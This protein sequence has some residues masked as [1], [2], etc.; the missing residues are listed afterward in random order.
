MPRYRV[1]FSRPNQA[2]VDMIIEAD[3]EEEARRLAYEQSWHD[4]TATPDATLPVSIA[5]YEQPSAPEPLIGP[6]AL[7]AGATAPRTWDTA[8]GQTEEARAGSAAPDADAQTE[9]DADDKVVSFE[10]FRKRRMAR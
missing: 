5:L 9:D 4:E 6:A 8:E 3:N 10:A 2:F 1:L 7:A